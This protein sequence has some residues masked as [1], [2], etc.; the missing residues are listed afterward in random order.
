MC[1][2]DE[3]YC[4]DC[5]ELFF[6]KLYYSFWLWGFIFICWVVL[7]YWYLK[8]KIVGSWKFDG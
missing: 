4:M 1:I 8:D 6:F 2:K 7:M 5:M 3:F